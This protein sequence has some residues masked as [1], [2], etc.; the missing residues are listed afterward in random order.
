MQSVIRQQMSVNSLSGQLSSDKASDNIERNLTVDAPLSAHESPTFLS[1]APGTCLGKRKA[2]NQS[3][4]RELIYPTGAA[5]SPKK[6]KLN[7]KNS[8]TVSSSLNLLHESSAAIRD[9][10]QA[11]PATSDGVAETESPDAE[12]NSSVSFSEK[13]ALKSGNKKINLRDMASLLRCD[14][15][16]LL[17]GNSIVMNAGNE[18]ALTVYN[19]K[20]AA[21]KLPDDVVKNLLAEDEKINSEVK[22]TFDKSER[23]ILKKGNLS[24]QQVLNNTHQDWLKIRQ[25]KD[26]T[27][28]CI[29]TRKEITILMKLH[30]K[31]QAPTKV[32]RL[33]WKR[34]VIAAFVHAGRCSPVNQEDKLK[35]Q[36]EA[37]SLLTRPFPV[38]LSS[39]PG[40]RA[41]VTTCKSQHTVREL[42]SPARVT[43]SPALVTEKGAV[44]SGNKKSATVAS[45][46]QQEVLEKLHQCH[47]TIPG[48]NET[49][50]TIYDEREIEIKLLDTEILALSSVCKDFKEKSHPIIRR[51]MRDILKKVE[52][53]YKKEEEVGKFIEVDDASLQEMLARKGGDGKGLIS[54]I[55]QAY[56]RRFCSAGQSCIENKRFTANEAVKEILLQ[57]TLRSRP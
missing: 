4:D 23:N 15:L 19:G 20:Q 30:S 31:A 51:P 44:E 5:I 35:N 21:I 7:D 42:I 8:S 32:K 1:A 2:E 24:L 18:A 37:R 36:P 48:Y 22:I 3:D 9:Q 25:R 33:S 41:A 39:F 49:A 28:K 34:Q 26:R 46:P 12:V 54:G 57:A 53:N 13:D 52:V 40:R 47:I 29:W 14:L 17:E 16:R 55:E 56:L 50:R 38:T 43:R 10:N 6:I 27:G 45:S 11:I